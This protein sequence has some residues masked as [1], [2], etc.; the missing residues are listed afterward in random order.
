LF[1][2]MCSDE[3]FLKHALGY[4]TRSYLPFDPSSRSMCVYMYVCMQN[5]A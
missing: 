2:Q 1:G 4:T 3:F 5:Y